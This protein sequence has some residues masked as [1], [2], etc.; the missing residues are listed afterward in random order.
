MYFIAKY[1]I[2]NNKGSILNRTDKFNYLETCGEFEIL[3]NLCILLAVLSTEKTLVLSK[4]KMALASMP[5]DCFNSIY[6][7]VQH[8]KFQ[9]AHPRS[10]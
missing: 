10:N 3:V 5:E 9:K 8:G 4:I 7:Q 2:E 1:N 6:W